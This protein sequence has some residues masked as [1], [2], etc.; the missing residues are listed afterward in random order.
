[1]TDR[2]MSEK[3]LAG[4]VL[5][6]GIAYLNMVGALIYGIITQGKTEDVDT[7]SIIAIVS[8]VALG[9]GHILWAIHR[10][11]TLKSKDTDAD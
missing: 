1:M 8:V 3:R 6:G 7:L 4:L 11:L 5:F 10:L 9:I 2:R